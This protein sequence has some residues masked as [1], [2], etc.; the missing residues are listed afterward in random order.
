MVKLDQNFHITK[1]GVVKKNPAKRITKK[2]VAE[3]LKAGQKAADDKFRAMV[4]AGDQYAITDESD[5][6]KQY[7]LLGL[8]GFA[9]I[10]FR[11]IKIK[12]DLVKAG[13]I[14]VG[15]NYYGG[16]NTFFTLNC[17]SW[18]RKLHPEAYAYY[19]Q[20]IDLKSAGYEGFLN[21][22]RSKGLMMDAYVDSRID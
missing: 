10:F 5:P 2:D 16:Y 6:S 17:P 19:N 9:W 15:K 12:N 11:G 3:A 8:C 22:M 18:A 7:G 20:S 13:S 21:S 4:G 1:A 14:R